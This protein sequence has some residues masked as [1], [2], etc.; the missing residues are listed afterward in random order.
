[1][2]F[3]QIPAGLAAYTLMSAE[4]PSSIPRRYPAISGEVPRLYQSVIDGVQR[5]W[6]GRLPTQRLVP[7]EARGWYRHVDKLWKAADDGPDHLL[8][9]L[10]RHASQHRRAMVDDKRRARLSSV[11]MF[12][13][14]HVPVILARVFGWTLQGSPAPASTKS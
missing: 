1:M 9:D 11:T 14:S 2:S 3:L 12:H 10:E 8:S 5:G 6:L 7:S 4:Q 13:I